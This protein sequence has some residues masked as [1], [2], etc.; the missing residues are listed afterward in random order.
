MLGW[1]VCLGLVVGVYGCSLQEAGATLALQQCC[2]VTGPQGN[3]TVEQLL[4]V[5]CVCQVLS[6]GGPVGGGCVCDT[7]CLARVRRCGNCRP[8]LQSR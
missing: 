3:R 6:V 4:V 7:L 2:R 8:G 1:Y 5:C